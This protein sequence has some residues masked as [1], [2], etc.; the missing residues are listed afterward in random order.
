MIQ[1]YFLSIFYLVLSALIYYQS[2]YRM[3]LSFMLRFMNL[4]EKNRRFYILFIS[5]GFLTFLIL[6]F[7]PIYPG[8][9]ILGDLI[10]SLMVLY[11]T[12]YFLVMIKRKEKNE[13]AE[14]YLDMKSLSRK[15]FLARLSIIVAIVHFF[16]PSFVLL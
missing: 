4:L 10:P 12:L 1:G 7:F 6:F 5:C 2:K 9:M 3:E 14:N 8:P 16:L 13:K 11:N 15:L